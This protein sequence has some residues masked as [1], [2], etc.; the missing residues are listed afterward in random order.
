MKKK[1]IH[2]AEDDLNDRQTALDGFCPQL[3]HDPVFRVRRKTA[4]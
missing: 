2:A 4:G 1:A 3:I